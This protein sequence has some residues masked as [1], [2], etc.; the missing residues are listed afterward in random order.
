MALKMEKVWSTALSFLDD[1]PIEEQIPFKIHMKQ[2]ELEK[3]YA[4]SNFYNLEEEEQTKWNSI[5]NAQAH[6][7]LGLSSTLGADTS[8]AWKKTLEKMNNRVAILKLHRMHASAQQKCFDMLIGSM[9]S[10]APIQTNYPS[11]ELRNFDQQIAKTCLKSNGLS[12]SD[13]KIRMFLPEC[14]GG[15]GFSSTLEMDL[16]SIMREFE[17]IANNVAL[18]SKAF[19]TRVSALRSYAPTENIFENQNHARDALMKMAKYG[20][21]VRDSCDFILND[22]LA[23]LCAKT[24]RSAVGPPNLGRAQA[25]YSALSFCLLGKK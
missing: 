18:D 9:K 2:A 24:K 10:F 6:K 22:I 17:I 1:A 21:F 23:D 12:K 19:R 20:I 3:F 13:C 11:L 14:K 4:I 15:L 25:P 16:I 8:T 5:I 7:H